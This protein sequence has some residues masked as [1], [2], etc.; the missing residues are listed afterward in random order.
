MRLSE[1]SLLRARAGR[2]APQC[3]NTFNGLYM[4]DAIDGIKRAARNSPRRA[5]AA[6]IYVLVYQ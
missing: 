1:E 4:W 6:T 2:R 5:L 3:Y